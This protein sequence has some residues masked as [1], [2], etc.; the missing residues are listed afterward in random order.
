MARPRVE[1]VRALFERFNS[2]D[3]E[4][5]VGLLAEDFVAE[6]PPSLSA[7]PDVYE[8]REGALRYMRAFEGMLED[9]RFE[10]LEFHEEGDQ[11]IVEM[12]LKGRGVSS[13]IEVTQRVAV[14]NWV[15]DEEVK[16]MQPFPDLDAA[17][18]HL[19]RNE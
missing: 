10:P 18:R 5:A 2:D 12:L 16:R 6:V 4:S 13:G 15:E 7:E 9:V 19:G 14:V 11:V 1:V 17:R 3:P 8:G